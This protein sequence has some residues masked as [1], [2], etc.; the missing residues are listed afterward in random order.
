MGI[1]YG[2]CE[3][4]RRRLAFLGYCAVYGEWGMAVLSG[5]CVVYAE[6]EGKIVGCWRAAIFLD[7]AW[8]VQIRD[9]EEG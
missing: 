6:K 5:Y 1:Q 4:V 8:C 3:L 7:I 2:V 9:S